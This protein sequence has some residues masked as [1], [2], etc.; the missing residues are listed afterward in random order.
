[1]STRTSTALSFLNGR[2]RVFGWA[3]LLPRGCQL[4]TDS[5]T[6]INE[7]SSEELKQSKPLWMIYGAMHWQ[8]MEWKQL[9]RAQSDPYTPINLKRIILN[10]W[11]MAQI[12][13][14]LS[15]MREVGK[16]NKKFS[17]QNL[18]ERKRKT[19]S[20]GKSPACFV[21]HPSWFRDCWCTC[22]P[23]GWLDCPN[24]SF[25]SCWR[26]RSCFE[27]SRTQWSPRG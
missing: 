21:S 12:L 18:Q 8:S 15:G 6:D 10:A 17:N 11:I 16:Q 25:L 5:R 7:W 22:D 24:F 3:T 2:E 26:S 14:N 27:R 13:R 4:A 9:L 20:G 23:C 1:M 19:I